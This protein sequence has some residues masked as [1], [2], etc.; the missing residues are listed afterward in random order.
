MRRDFGV[1]FPPIFNNTIPSVQTAN[2][3]VHGDTCLDI[4]YQ[5]ISSSRSSL[6]DKGCLEDGW[7]RFSWPFL[8]LGH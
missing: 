2:H 7:L 5:L 3:G 1:I 6:G 8:L 4:N